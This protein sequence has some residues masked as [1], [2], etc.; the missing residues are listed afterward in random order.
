MRKALCGFAAWRE[1]G[2]RRRAT[3]NSMSA[4]AR[5]KHENQDCMLTTSYCKHEM[6]NC[7]PATSHCKPA[8]P[9]VMSATPNCKSSNPNCRPVMARCRSAN[10]S[11]RQAEG[12]CKPLWCNGLWHETPE[13]SRQG[14]KAQRNCL[15]GGVAALGEPKGACRPAGR[16]VA[17]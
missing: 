7:R 9:Y 11:C 6:P 3:A 4:M 16:E 10:R 1:I 5:C 13:S 15:L 12:C 14:A 2:E 17:G 8:M